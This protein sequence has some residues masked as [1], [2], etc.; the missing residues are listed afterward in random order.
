MDLIFSVFLPPLECEAAQFISRWELQ[1]DLIDWEWDSA[2]VF[3]M[4][5]AAADPISVIIMFLMDI[6]L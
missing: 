4:L 2:V 6:E 5:I 1:E 3:D